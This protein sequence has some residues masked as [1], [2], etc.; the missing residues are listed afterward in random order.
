MYKIYADDVLIY[1]S[2]LDDYKIG[3]GSITKEAGKSGSFVFTLYPDH[4]CYDS[5]V[6]MRT[7]VTAYKFNRIVFRG[8]VLNDKTDY[9]NT[10]ELT[11]EGDMGFL[12]DSIIRPYTFTGS[13]ADLFAQLVA[14]HNGQ[15]DEFKRFKV[16]TVTVTDPVTMDQTGYVTAAENINTALIDAL[17]GYLHITYEDDGPTLH[18]LADFTATAT[19]VI[20]FGANLKNYTKTVKAEDMATAIIPLGATVDDG[21]SDTEDPKLTIASVNA[22]KD[23]IYSAEGVAL[24]GWI[25]KVVEWSDVTEAADLKAKAEAYLQTVVNQAVTIELNAIDL[26][27]LD[28]SI[29]SFNV[30]EYVRVVSAPHGFAATM[31][32]NKQML[33][34]LKPENDT[35]TLGHTFAT[36]TEKNTKA[37]N[38]VARL[39]SLQ[40]SAIKLTNTLAALANATGQ[41]SAAIVEIIAR[42]DALAGDGPGDETDDPTI[43]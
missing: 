37:L 9:W 39:A 7:V 43:V 38:S 11:C 25:V 19:Q 16:G 28:R 35:V 2:T 1:D 12:Q 24:Y 14:Q 32:C 10:K 29:E 27:L 41:N 33:D 31:L 6:R 3:K 26:H 22:G 34:L 5:I 36:F 4:P 8:R 42:L 21:N 40:S 13:A 15:V 18:Y 30:C 20:E 17:G 23:Y